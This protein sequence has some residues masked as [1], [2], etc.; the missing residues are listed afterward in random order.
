MAPPALRNA[1]WA[2]RH[3]RSEA[4]ERGIIVSSPARGVAAFGLSPRGRAEV[5]AA[6]APARLAAR[7]L[8]LDPARSLVVSS[9]FLRARKTAEILCALNALPVP[10][11]DPRLR[12]R[13]FGDLD[14]GPSSAY[15][16]VWARDRENDSHHAFGCESPAEVRAR[17]AGLIADL[18]RAEAGRVIV[19]VAHGDVLQ[20]A[21]TFFAGVECGRHREMP[22]LETGEM[23]TLG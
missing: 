16:Q 10:R 19:L 21:Q 23:R 6:L 2:L 22:H 8:A 18:E 20:I 17:V 4:N 7:G 12:E 5:L 9:D 3:G 11:L 13:F 1:Y 14:G 15:E